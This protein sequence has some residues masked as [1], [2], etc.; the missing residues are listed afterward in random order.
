MILLKI[1]PIL[2]ILGA[3]AIAFHQYF[4]YGM[5]FQ[6]DDIHHETFMIAFAFCGIVLLI[7]RKGR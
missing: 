3:V 1:L 6:L 2:L 7:I 5:W 4:F